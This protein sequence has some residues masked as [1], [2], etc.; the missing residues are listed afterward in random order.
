[1]MVLASKALSVEFMILSRQI[2][3][4]EEMV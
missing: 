1:M 2:S 3:L 4:K